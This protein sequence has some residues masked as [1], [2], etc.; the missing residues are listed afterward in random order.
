MSSSRSLN[1]RDDED[2][3]ICQA[4]M[5]VSQDPIVG[6]SQS[7]DKFWARIAT[8]FNNAKNSSYEIRSRKSIQSRFKDHIAP[9]IK[10]LVHSIKHVELQ[11]PSGASELTILERAKVFYANSD[12]KKFKNGFK[13]DHVWH[14]LKDFEL[15]QDNAPASPRISRKHPSSQSDNEYPHCVTPDSTG[16]SQ[17]D[18]DLNADDNNA[19]VGV[20]II[21]YAAYMLNQWHHHHH[22]FPP[23]PDVINPLNLA[24]GVVSFNDI[25]S[26]SLPPPWFIY[27]FMGVG[28]LV[29]CITCIGHIAA[30][31]INGCCLC[32]VSFFLFFFFYA[33]QVSVSPAAKE[34]CFLSSL[35]H[36]LQYVYRPEQ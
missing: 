36:D 4:Y 17:F 26:H 24:S 8:I 13:F 23:P 34:Y 10:R 35:D 31:A 30:E 19:F 3:I 2:I 12:N 33:P 18:V 15:F 28:I 25:N 9:A 6:K 5:E 22:Q 14:I 20:A 11:N 27:A 21:V 32:F 7:S 1:Y 29:C 16:F